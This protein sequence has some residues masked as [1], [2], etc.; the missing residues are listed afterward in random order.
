VS[1][2][3][4]VWNGSEATDRLREAI[5]ELN[6]QT[7]KQATAMVRLTWVL[8]ALTVVLVALTIVLLLQG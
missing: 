5:V 2:P 6:E 8:V 3:L 7:A 4:N 1:V